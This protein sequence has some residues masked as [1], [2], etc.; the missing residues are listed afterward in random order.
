MNILLTALLW[1]FGI[2]ALFLGIVGCF[3]AI[4]LLKIF[5]KALNTAVQ[6]RMVGGELPKINLKKEVCDGRTTKRRRV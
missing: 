1:T 6:V 3:F 2:L 4:I 5:F